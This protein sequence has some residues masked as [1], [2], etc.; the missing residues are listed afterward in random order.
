M[1]TKRT[2]WVGVFTAFV[3]GCFVAALLGKAS[4][5]LSLIIEELGLNLFE[6]GLIISLFSVIAATGGLVLGIFAR[7]VGQL[8]GA[9][10]G[11]ACAVGG[12]LFG[13]I[14]ES[15]LFLLLSRL[16]EGL[17]FILAAVSLPPLIQ[18]V[19]RSQDQ[20]IAM[21]LWGA[22]MPVG[23]G[24]V[25][26]LA[27]LL[28]DQFGWRGT[29]NLIAAAT[30]VWFGITW[31]V[32]RNRIQQTPASSAGAVPIRSILFDA[33]TVLMFL[34]FIGYSALFTPVGSL[35]PTLL[36]DQKQLS[37]TLAAQL[38]AIVVVANI[39]GNFASGWLIKRGYSPAGLIQL[40]FVAMGLLGVVVFLDITS[41][42]L[43]VLAGFLFSAIG[44]LIPGGLFV[45]IA[46][47]SQAPG[48]VAILAGVLLQGA[49]FG[50][51][52]GPMAAT[53]IAESMARW[54]YVAVYILVS[55]VIGLY[56]SLRLGR[57]LGRY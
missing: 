7:R 45:I 40:A 17:G 6:A 26:L 2:Y 32:F 5:G 14:S 51:V 12:G 43:K 54:D 20:P 48:Q 38:G 28:L 36:V 18:Q 39:I 31:L 44:G 9:L 33:R 47:I 16:I 19:C 56:F 8:Y 57:V 30:L 10:L 15:F 29:W 50:Q 41:P 49:G 4:A 23:M 37:V 35:L 53:A 11:L 46:R 27:P 13:A 55:G 1:N 21:G 52:F 42:G 24:S 34:C 25:M 3:A 22:F